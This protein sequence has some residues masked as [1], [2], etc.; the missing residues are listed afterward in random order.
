MVSLA[1][2]L[3]LATVA[4]ST[5]APARPFTPAQLQANSVHAA[6][7]ILV[8]DVVSWRLTDVDSAQGLVGYYPYHVG[9]RPR[10]WLEGDEGPGTFTVCW[11]PPYDTPRPS[12]RGGGS[13]PFPLAG[14]TFVVFA[15][16]P[17]GRSAAAESCAWF[18]IPDASTSF[19]PALTPWTERL[20]TDIRVAIQ[21]QAPQELARHAHRVVLGTIERVPGKT[22]A[23]VVRVKRALKG[24]SA[25]AKLPMHWFDD[26]TIAWSEKR[27]WLVFLHLGPDGDY[28]PVEG[29]AG[30]VAVDGDRVPAWGKTLDEA[31]DLVEQAS[32]PG[33][34]K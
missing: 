29:S 12:L 4:T 20:E 21:R 16:R 3:A 13:P 23:A 30:I 22:D 7:R 15:E 33:S 1:L 6:E 5:M 14:K 10:R 26:G 34:T 27:S 25:P 2:T 11:W 31:E 19:L 17:V 32:K 9:I 8:G 28:E 24:G 18:M